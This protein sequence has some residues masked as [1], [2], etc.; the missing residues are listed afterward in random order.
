[1]TPSAFAVAKIDTQGE[2]R[3]FLDRQIGAGL[4]P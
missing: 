3:W 1:M 2:L 4:V